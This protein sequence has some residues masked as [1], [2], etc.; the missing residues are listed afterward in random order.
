[1]AIYLIVAGSTPS[2]SGLFE[3]GSGLAVDF[4]VVARQGY[5]Q[6]IGNGSL[7]VIPVT[8]NLSTRDVIVQVYRNSSPWD[9]VDVDVTRNSTSQVTLTFA[10]APATNAYTVVV[11]PRRT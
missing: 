4:A 7:T 1:M 10:V 3:S 8:H 6:T 2:S 11:M 9:T 5:S